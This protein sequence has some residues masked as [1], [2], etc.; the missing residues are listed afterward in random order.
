MNKLLFNRWFI[1]A[2][3][4]MLGG[5]F[6][7]ASLDK[8]ANPEAFAKAINNY[9]IMP[10]WSLNLMAIYMPWVEMITGILII[11]GKFIK[12]SVVI[13]SF[14]LVVFLIAITSALFRGLDISCGCFSTAGGQRIGLLKLIEDTGY[15]VA[16]IIVY[17]DAYRQKNAVNAS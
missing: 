4:L 17:I 7:Y 14:M 10:D 12:G 2:L 3:R 9:R 1:L 8:I 11:F 5:V 6:I 15:L 13:I 16:C